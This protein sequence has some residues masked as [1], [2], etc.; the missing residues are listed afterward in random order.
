MPIIKTIVRFQPDYT[1]KAKDVVCETIYEAEH[2]FQ[3]FK[4]QGVKAEILATRQ[5]EEVLQT[6]DANMRLG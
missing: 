6:T 5:A 1:N 4:N 3:W 2:L